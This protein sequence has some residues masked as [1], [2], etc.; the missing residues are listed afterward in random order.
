M[1]KQQALRLIVAAQDDPIVAAWVGVLDEHKLSPDAEV[2]PYEAWDTF[3][4]LHRHGYVSDSSL[5]TSSLKR[6]FFGRQRPNPGRLHQAFYHLKILP[7]EGIPEVYVKKSDNPFAQTEGRFLERREPRGGLAAREA[8]TSAPMGPPLNPFSGSLQQGPPAVESPGL[9]PFSAPGQSAL[10][11]REE[12]LPP[13]PKREL[14]NHAKVSRCLECGR[15]IILNLHIP[16][17][18]DESQVRQALEQIEMEDKVY[19]G[20]CACGVITHL[21]LGRIP[22]HVVR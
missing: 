10:T 4:E 17:D 2:S 16:Q 22:P 9:N 12:E 20:D 6:A 5:N 13:Q 3:Q 7:T 11:C 15:E 19:Y 1:N 14:P 8:P 21:S 18:I